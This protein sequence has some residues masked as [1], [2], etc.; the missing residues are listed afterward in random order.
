MSLTTGRGP[1]STRP[2]GRF[3][4]VLLIVR[5]DCHPP[6]PGSVMGPETLVPSTSLQPLVPDT[7]GPGGV[8]GHHPGGGEPMS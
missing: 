6:V 2:A 3:R 7:D 8:G 5:Q 4:P 1:L